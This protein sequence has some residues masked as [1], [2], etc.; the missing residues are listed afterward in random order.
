MKQATSR[1]LAWL[2][3]LVVAAAGPA[4]AELEDE[5]VITA[6][7]RESTLQKTNISV[8]TLSS[9]ELEARGVAQ[10]PDLTQFVPNINFQPNANGNGFFVSSRAV[11]QGDAT[12]I[13][14]DP[15]TAIYI[16]GVYW[17]I[18]IGNLL[19]VLDIERVE[20]LRGPQGDLYGRNSVAGAINF[21]TRKPS[22]GAGGY[23][24]V[25]AGNHRRGD[26][27]SYL[28]FPLFEGGLGVWSGNLSAAT[29]NRDAFYPNLVGDDIQ[30]EKRIAFRTALRGEDTFG[31]EWLTTDIVVDYTFADE[32]STEMQLTGTSNEP[33]AF[34]VAQPEQLAL[35]PADDEAGNFGGTLGINTSRNT[36]LDLDGPSTRGFGLAHDETENI[37]FSFTLGY[38]VQ[39]PPVFDD[40]VLKSIVG[41]RGVWSDA[42][43]DLDGTPA[44]IFSTRNDDE[45]WQVTWEGNIVTALETDFGD[46]DWL[47]GVFV[48]H[49]EG[50][51][52]S[53]Q[54]SDRQ[55][56]QDTFP[57]LENDA[58]AVY[59]H[60]AYIP[61]LWDDRIKAEAGVRYTFEDR[62]ID[63]FVAF[64]GGGTFE[65]SASEDFD[66]VTP[67]F[68]LSVEVLRDLQLDDL[69]LVRSLNVYGS[70]AR[71]FLSGGFNGR[72]ATVGTGTALDFD[73][74]YRPETLWSYEGGFKAQ[75]LD[76]RVRMTFAGFY[77]DYKDLQRT[78]L[79]VDPNT[80]A[81]GS[82]VE[83]ADEANIYGIEIEAL[84]NPWD[85]VMVNI[86][87]GMAIAEYELFCDTDLSFM[88]PPDPRCPAGQIDFSDDRNF[89][90]TPEH[91]LTLGAQHTVDV[92]VG[93]LT[94]R[95]DYYWQS[96]TLLQNGDDEDAG[97]DAYGILNARISLN[98][99]ELPGDAG[100]V[101]LAIWG[102]NLTDE[103]YRPFGIDF[104]SYIVQMFGPRRTYGLDVTWRFGSML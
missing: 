60:A 4:T 81:I 21:I 66:E 20:A 18:T 10:I 100:E 52:R 36:N 14:R 84:I 38:P 6:Q 86:G 48:F 75:G 13:T 80:M 49:E 57:N 69:Q 50:Q 79:L 95:I 9:G 92:G 53:F 43:T 42:Y 27:R 2:G 7:K 102:R 59:S 94:G 46:V 99:L 67:T 68:R 11:G 51:G 71:G 32:Q 58:Y 98:G 90:N 76:D 29:I 61:P 35:L 91:N 28:E 104:A 63:Q 12:N 87:Y 54:S 23:T 17:G 97:E 19:D 47:I 8:T 96:E 83:N 30:S 31:I 55:A 101:E 33:A 65:G 56:V 70:A 78:A 45:K 62:S 3:V 22:G 93:A 39:D 82:G 24:T 77:V 5:I 44:D 40:I 64:G 73:S 103:E 26:L 25:R 15:A 34:L 16:D 74:F 85:E 88:A 89:A 1:T 41:Y 37:G 72:A